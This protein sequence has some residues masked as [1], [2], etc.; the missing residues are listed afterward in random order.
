MADPRDEQTAD[1][2]DVERAVIAAADVACRQASCSPCRSQR[3]AVVFSIDSPATA[4][5]YGRG[6]NHKPV[7]FK[8]DG[9]AECKG[10]CRAEAVHAEQMALL[11]AGRDAQGADLLH[12]KIVNGELVPSGEP[13]CVQCSKLALAAGI[14]NVWLYH[15]SGWR[16][17]AATEFHRLSLSA[18]RQEAQQEGAQD[19]EIARARANH[20]I[21]QR[22]RAEIAFT[23]SERKRLALIDALTEARQEI[24]RLTAVALEERELRALIQDTAKVARGLMAPTEAVRGVIEPLL[25][26]IERLRAA[27]GEQLRFLAHAMRKVLPPK[28][29]QEVIEH[30]DPLTPFLHVLQT[31][32]LAGPTAP[33]PIFG[34]WPAECQQRAFVEGAK[35]WQFKANGATA[36]PSE[37]D[38]MEAEAV[39]R[40]GRP[41]EANSLHCAHCGEKLT[42]PPGALDNKVVR[43]ACGGQNVLEVSKVCE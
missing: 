20:E 28:L 3:G 17:Y 6:H 37:V 9:S 4:S 25:Q 10:N 34:T 42:L 23:Q 1:P 5:I 22:E 8:C 13:S 35:W 43:C 40:Y 11:N 21:S 14:G 2:R 19:A 31:A 29:L 18:V 15:E 38:E 36:F 7:G 41:T 24:E 26:E 33:T 16:R 30:L 39:T 27:E 12:V 32:A